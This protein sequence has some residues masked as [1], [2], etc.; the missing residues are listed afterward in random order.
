MLVG[1]FGLAVVIYRGIIS[2][3]GLVIL[4]V[5]LELNVSFGWFVSVVAAALIV[6]G[7]LLTYLAAPRLGP[8]S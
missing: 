3:P 1:L 7:G 4:G 8:L 6:L 2:P 5:E